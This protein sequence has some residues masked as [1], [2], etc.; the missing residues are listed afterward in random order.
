[1]P[2]YGAACTSA[3]EALGAETMQTT[4]GW[5]RAPDARALAAICEAADL[6]V[7]MTSHTL[8]Y[9]PEIAAALERGARVLC[10]MEPPHVLDRLRF[11]PDVRTKAMSGTRLLDAASQIHITSPAGTD[12]KM[13]KTGQCGLANYG[14]ADTAGH[15][16]FWGLG[17]V[18]AAQLE[19]TTEGLLV[20][21]VGDCVFQ[22]G[23]FV[24]APVPIRFNAGRI[25]SIWNAPTEVV[26][27]L[28]YDYPV[29]G[30]L[31]DGWK[32]RET[33]R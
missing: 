28:G 15:L 6:I 9:C 16:D 1:M 27:Q 24:E 25:I 4:F 7:Y 33:R 11:D 5:N 14:A 22:H 29:L 2:A 31:N 13:D 32:T 10:C 21:D 30:G 19:G 3:A 12:L 18:Q 23:R 8:H 26:H 17:A 20:L